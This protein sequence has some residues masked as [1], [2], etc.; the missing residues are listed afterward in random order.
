M[1]PL[2]YVVI[3]NPKEMR[4]VLNFYRIQLRDKVGG[5][6]P[7]L[8]VSIGRRVCIALDKVHRCQSTI[9][10]LFD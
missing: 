6:A 5:A 7:E 2:D 9:K 4:N 1:I 3:H 8:E 10:A